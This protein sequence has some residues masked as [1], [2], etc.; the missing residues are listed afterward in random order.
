MLTQSF[1]RLTFPAP[2]CWLALGLGLAISTI[3]AA[4]R[5]EAA[6]IERRPFGKTRDG[7]PV[8][9]YIL[10]SGSQEVRILTLGATLRAWT[11]PDK[12]GKM[13]DVLL[14][15]DDVAGYESAD[16]QY[17]GCTVGRVCNRIGGARF[18]LEGKHYQLINNDGPNQLH[19][20]NGR[21]LCR[22]IW[23]AAEQA[24]IPD[25]AAVKFS[26][27]SPAGEEGYPGE[28]KASVTYALAADGK[29]TL[30]YSAITDAATPVNL[31]N[32]AYFNLAGAGAPTILDHELKLMA[33]Q[34]TPVDSTLIPTGELAAV[35]GTALDFNAATA[36]GARIDQ[37]SGPPTIGYDHNYALRATDGKVRQVAVV[38]HPG[39]GRVLEVHT[40]QPGLQFYSG[41]FLKDQPGKGGKTYAHRSAFCLE[42]QHF[43]NSVNEPRFPSIILR[44]GETYTQTTIYW[45]K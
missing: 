20:G 6:E 33:D 8:D 4:S 18:D 15:F 26:Y 13:A 28:L 10:R 1:H 19:G 35:A 25:I 2:I 27:T 43:P 44:P 34:Y 24:S 9:E 31:T 21:A 45:L 39:T 38:R 41:N 22:V 36:I 32:H 14:G 30:T 37:V 29:L 16:N 17:F 5:S 42:A 12:S 11:A 40:D 3:G 7:A 23:Q